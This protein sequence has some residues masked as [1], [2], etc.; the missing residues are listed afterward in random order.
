M[1]TQHAPPNH[2]ADYPGVA[3]MAGLVAALS[4]AFGRQGDAPLAA[5]LSGLGSG[6]TVVDLGVVPE[7]QSATQPERVRSQPGSTQHP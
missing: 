6:D 2:H 7:P 5:R 4:M 1:D 3:G